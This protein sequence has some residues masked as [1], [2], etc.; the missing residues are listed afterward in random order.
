MVGRT[1]YTTRQLTAEV[2]STSFRGPMT[3]WA[4]FFRELVA[5]ASVI[6]GTALGWPSPVILAI[7]QTGCPFNMTDDEL[8][9]MVSVP[10]QCRLHHPVRLLDERHWTEEN[11]P[12]HDC[13]RL[14]GPSLHCQV[15]H[16]PTLREV[17]SRPIGRY[18]RHHCTH[19]RS[20]NFPT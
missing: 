16:S 6:V 14:L 17:P 19:V 15:S 3:S 10:R 8:A 18:C 1:S 9:L 5:S 4:G 2:S 12:P 11:P 13:H 20:R 7:K